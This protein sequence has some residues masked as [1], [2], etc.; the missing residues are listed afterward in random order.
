MEAFQDGVNAEYKK[1]KEIVLHY[2]VVLYEII[3]STKMFDTESNATH[4][5]KVLFKEII[6]L[7]QEKINRDL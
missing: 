1:N 5:E 2:Q 6:D 4:E 7:T 3:K